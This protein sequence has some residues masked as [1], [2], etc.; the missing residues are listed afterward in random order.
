MKELD[1]NGYRA[2]L[3]ECRKYR[4]TVS[5]KLDLSGVVALAIKTYEAHRKDSPEGALEAIGDTAAQLAKVATERNAV[6]DE[7]VAAINTL[8]VYEETEGGMGPKRPGN[9]NGDYIDVDAA[10]DAMQG[11]KV[12]NG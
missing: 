12:E 5:N 11:L 8:P 2:A 6:I 9:N 4:D 1:E 10:V 3:V 7:C